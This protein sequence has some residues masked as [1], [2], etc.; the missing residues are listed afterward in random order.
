MN[1]SE[2]ESLL[3]RWVQKSTAPEQERLER[4]KR[5]VTQAIENDAGLKRHM[6]Q[7]EIYPKG[8]YANETNVRFDSDVDIVVDNHRL[9]YYEWLPGVSPAPGTEI[10]PYDGPWDDPKAWRADV[11][12]A[13]K[14]YFGASEVDDS[15]EVA[16]TIKERPGSRPSADVVP[17]FSFRRYDSADR[18]NVAEG[19]KVFMKTTGSIINY[20]KQQLSNGKRKDANTRGRYKQFVRALKNSENVLVKE[21]LMDAKPSYFMECLVWNVPNSV[22]VRGF[23]LATG[24]QEVLGSLYE[25]LSR[26]YTYEDWTEPNDLKYL[27]A[28]GNKWSVQDGVE[29]VE[30]TWKYLGY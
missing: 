15:G 26:D 8:S 4:A 7:L 12:A 6:H 22:L 29:L 16:I 23:S 9:F 17:G 14:N 24:F 30:K 27:F 18:R 13:L 19:S 2:R 28:N 1:S 20:P 21:G 11:T 25:H 10:P 3:A 5:M